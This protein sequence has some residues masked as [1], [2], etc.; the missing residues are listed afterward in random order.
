MTALGS[1]LSDSLKEAIHAMYE[2]LKK[3]QASKK[4]PQEILESNGFIGSIQGDA[5][6]S[7]DYKKIV[8]DIVKAKHEK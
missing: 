5:N 3:E 4:T 2:N 1:N 7:A 8:R 6:W